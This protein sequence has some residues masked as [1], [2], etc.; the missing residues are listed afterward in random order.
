MHEFVERWMKQLLEWILMSKSCQIDQVCCK[1]WESWKLHLNWKKFAQKKL[2][3]RLL[4]AVWISQKT[5]K[6]SGGWASQKYAWNPY[7]L[8]IS[9]GLKLIN[10]LLL[11]FSRKLSSAQFPFQTQ[12][13]LSTPRVTHTSNYCTVLG[14]YATISFWSIS[15][16]HTEYLHMGQRISS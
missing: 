14:T 10:F 7:I 1:I 3:F 11:P 16:A 4:N 15:A 2:N 9:V 8:Q 12:R 6:G 13:R 5:S